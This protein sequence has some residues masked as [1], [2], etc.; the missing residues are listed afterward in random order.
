MD[1]E[2]RTRILALDIGSK[3]TG[4]AIS[5]PSQSISLP[6]TNVEATKKG[7]WVSKVK[8]LVETSDV[9]KIVVGIPL[10]H[11]GEEGADAQKIREFIALLRERVT[12]PVIEWDERF[13]T[14]QAERTLVDADLSRK[15]RKQVIDKIA[16][17]IILQ[18]Y[19]DSL[20]F[21]KALPWDDS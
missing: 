3:R 2:E 6:L 16:A 11:H 15:R 1:F 4:V 8:D 10:D 18:S 14:V 17:T 21:R 19:L 12:Q 13:T 9:E 5:D 7:E 20:H